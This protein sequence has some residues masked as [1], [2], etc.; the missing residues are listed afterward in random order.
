[1]ALKVN[2]T[3]FRQLCWKKGF[4]GVSGLARSLKRNRS[5][6]HHAINNP[7]RYGPTMKLIEQTLL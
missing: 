1:M 2:K 7:K 5:V 3:N 4:H 6:L